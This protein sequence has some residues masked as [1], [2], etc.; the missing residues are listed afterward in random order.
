MAA[1]EESAPLSGLGELIMDPPDA[2][3]TAVDTV[4][5]PVLHAALPPGGLLAECCVGCL[6]KA[7]TL[8]L[9]SSSLSCQHVTPAAVCT[10][11]S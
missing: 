4:P 6:L 2:N 10:P 1:A 8:C 5:S 9:D 11:M 3:S 7:A